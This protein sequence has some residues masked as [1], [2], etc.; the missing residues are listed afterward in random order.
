MSK[1]EPNA[2]NKIGFAQS[3]LELGTR[4]SLFLPLLLNVCVQCVYQHSSDSC[5]F[6]LMAAY[7]LQLSTYSLL[8]L[9]LS[10][11]LESN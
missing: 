4:T 8:L 7:W 1:E 2:I 10:L 9:S 6:V 11:P 3:V 5:F